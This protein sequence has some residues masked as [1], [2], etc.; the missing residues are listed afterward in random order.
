MTQSAL[1]GKMYRAR[2]ESGGGEGAKSR[3]TMGVHHF[4]KAHSL[5]GKGDEVVVRWIYATRGL[6]EECF[7]GVC[8][9]RQK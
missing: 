3:D 6:S 5:V 7:Y 1:K 2:G 4:S 8:I 9:R